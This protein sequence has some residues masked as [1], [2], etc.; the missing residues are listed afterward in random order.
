MTSWTTKGIKGVRFMA[1][2]NVTFEMD[3][4]QWVDKVPISPYPINRNRFCNM[5]NMIYFYTHNVSRPIVL[6]SDIW[7][8]FRD[9]GYISYNREADSK[10][11]LSDQ[12]ET[13]LELINGKTLLVKEAGQRFF[14]EY[15][16][17]HIGEKRKKKKHRKSV[18]SKDYDQ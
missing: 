14:I 12:G 10:Y 9:N 6:P 2:F 3:D 1:I 17:A 8:V 7:K 5:I 13:L 16:Q 18:L 11:F 15:L 4:E